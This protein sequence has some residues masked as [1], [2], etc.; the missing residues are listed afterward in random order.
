MWEFARDCW[1][2][3]TWGRRMVSTSAKMTAAAWELKSAQ[4][5]VAASELKMALPSA[6]RMA[7]SM[8]T[9]SVLSSALLTVQLLAS[10]W[11]MTSASRLDPKRELPWVASATLLAQ[12]KAPEL[13]E[14]RLGKPLVQLSVDRMVVKLAFLLAD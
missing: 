1:L 11:A 2:A 8:D 4:M 14:Q 9:W 3:V 5:T 6:A 10:L 12:R 13:E 7:H